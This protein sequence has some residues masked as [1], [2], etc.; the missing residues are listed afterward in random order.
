MSGLQQA[1][2]LLVIDNYPDSKIRGANMEPTWVLLAPG[3]PPLAHESCYQG[4]S[5]N[6]I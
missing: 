6:L 2:S 3:G 4:T 5:S 1:Q